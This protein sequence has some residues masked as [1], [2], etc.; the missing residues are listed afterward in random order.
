MMLSRNELNYLDERLDDYKSIP[1]SIA[2]RK[3]EI[4]GDTGLSED[5][6]ITLKNLYLF[7]ITVEALEASLDMELRE[8]FRMRWIDSLS[9]VEIGERRHYADKVIYKK[10]RR[11]LEKYAEASGTFGGN[12]GK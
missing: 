1:H 5:S 11:I 2:V 6:D 8:V 4:E 12:H 3:I 9:W 10:R 7:Q